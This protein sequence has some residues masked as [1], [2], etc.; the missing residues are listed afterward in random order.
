MLIDLVMKKSLTLEFCDIT[1]YDNYL[2]VIMNEGVNL[3][4]EHNSVLID[5][6]NDY[7]NNKPFVYITHRL[8]SYSVD[9]KIY[10][11]T[12]KIKNLKGFAVVSGDY[13]AKSNAEVEKM[14][15]SKPFGIFSELDDAFKW[16]TE[17]VNK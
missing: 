8:N 3:K 7:Y 5:V 11:E 1:I 13:K 12:S 6:T 16:A 4:P 2:V 10:F 15:F 17:L 14:F 9:P